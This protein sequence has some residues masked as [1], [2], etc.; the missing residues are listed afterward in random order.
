MIHQIPV[1]MDDPLLNV[2]KCYEAVGNKQ[3]QQKI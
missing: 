3:I 2:P 1:F